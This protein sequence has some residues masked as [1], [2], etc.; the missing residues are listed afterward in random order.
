V[1]A[2]QANGI[3]QIILQ[4]QR[5]FIQANFVKITQVLNRIVEL[6]RRPRDP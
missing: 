1:F 6:G 2:N 5:Y 3:G 4:A